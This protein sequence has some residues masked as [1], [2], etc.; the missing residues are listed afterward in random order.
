MKKCSQMILNDHST[1]KPDADILDDSAA[2]DVPFIKLRD[3]NAQAFSMLS[4]ST[5][6]R[7]HVAV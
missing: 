5:K 4:L 1:L 7:S 6:R 3:H 2:A